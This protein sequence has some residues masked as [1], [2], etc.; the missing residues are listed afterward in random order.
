M[1]V[2]L[3]EFSCMGIPRILLH[4]YTAYMLFKKAAFLRLKNIMFSND[5]ERFRR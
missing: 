1:H 2:L 3:A 4:A 5:K